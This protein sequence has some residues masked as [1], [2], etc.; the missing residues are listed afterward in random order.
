MRLVL[1][2]LALALAAG[3]AAQD[4]ADRSPLPEGVEVVSREAWGGGPP[5]A[6]MI[7]QTPVALTIHHSGTPSHPER[8][9]AETLRALYAF[10]TERTELADG[11]TREPWAD[12]P[13]H[14]YITPDGTILEARDVAVEGDTNTRYDLSDQVLVVVEGNFEEEVPTEAQMA[15]L[16]AL[17]E[18]LARQWGFGPATVAGHRDHA[19]GQTVCPG[20]ALEARFP[21]VRAAVARGARQSLAG[22]WTADL[23]PAPDAAPAPA[24]LVLAV[25]EA[26]RL[27]GSLGGAEIVGGRIDAAWDALRFTFST[28]A[29]DGTSVTHGA[30]RGGR[31][32][33]TTTA[34]D[35]ALSVWTATRAE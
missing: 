23:R 17:S 27:G 9:P 35:G 6:P 31:V 1:P 32:E 19:P 11:S 34:P 15:S 2:A 26:G 33:A 22:A 13:Y 25:T 3:A 28:R 29:A 4:A 16:L 30:V 18:A 5:V 20:D 21:E 12:I 8:A 14:F 10:S 24:D 7:P